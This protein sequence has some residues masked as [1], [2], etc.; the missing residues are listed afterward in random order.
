ML[1]FL[2]QLSWE[3]GVA[4]VEDV[5]VAEEEEGEDVASQ[6]MTLTTLLFTLSG[7]LCRLTL[8]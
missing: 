2:F 6:F 1:L 7:L 5:G 3:G 8:H 4:E